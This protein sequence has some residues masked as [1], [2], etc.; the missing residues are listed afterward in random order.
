MDPTKS[1]WQTPNGV[2]LYTRTWLPDAPVRAAVVLV[3]G[4]G[5]HCARYDHVASA[6]TDQGIA[7]YGFDHRGHGRSPGVR[8]HIPSFDAVF[9]DIDHF[10]DQANKNHP[11]KPVFVYGH[12][13]GGLLVLDFSLVRKPALLGV[14]CTSPGLATGNPVSPAK[15]IAAKILYTLVP[16]FTLPNGLDTQNL[17]HDQS[18]VQA[19]T[20]DPLVTP[21]ISARLGLDLINNG[22]WVS[23][24]AA[25]WTLPLLLMNGS[26]DHLVSPL[27]I[28]RFASAVP[29]K[30]IIY[31]EWEG[32]YHEIHNENGKERVI[33]DMLDWLNQH[34]GE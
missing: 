32:M 3:H 28:H 25:E 24:H 21:M 11:E 22:K 9:G 19:Y 15:L 6:F 13:L 23:E 8:G 17:S 2:K 5:E 27:A 16:K 12:S 31:K 20:S 33:H 14:I 1:F 10:V 26:A 18:V 4:L 30:T 7:V 29:Q 34:I